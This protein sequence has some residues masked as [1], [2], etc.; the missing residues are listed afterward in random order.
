MIQA[1]SAYYTAAFN[2]QALQPNMVENYH[3]G[4]ELLQKELASRGSTFLHGD[5]PGLV[6]YTIWPFLERFEALPLLGQADFAIDKDKYG[7]LVSKF[8]LKFVFF[9]FITISN[10]FTSKNYTTK[11]IFLHE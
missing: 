3:K 9:S 11:N 2:A 5:K 10:I 4:L 1:Q 8:N 6:D 7:L